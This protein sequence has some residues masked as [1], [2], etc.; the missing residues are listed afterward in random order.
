MFRHTAVFIAATLMSFNLKHGA[1]AEVAAP[2]A[3]GNDG[4]WIANTSEFGSSIYNPTID[5]LKACVDFNGALQA[6]APALTDDGY[7]KDTVSFPANVGC[8]VRP[9]PPGNSVRYIL[10]TH[11]KGPL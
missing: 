9:A 5:L 4:G 3:G 2:S 10:I 7:P 1:A 11:G 8:T 6:V